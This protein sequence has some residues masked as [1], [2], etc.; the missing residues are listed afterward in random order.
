VEAIE[1]SIGDLPGF[2]KA[3]RLTAKQFLEQHPGKR[4]SVVHAGNFSPLSDT[5]HLEM[6][7]VRRML[8]EL[9]DMTTDDGS[10][11]LGVSSM[12]PQFVSGT[13]QYRLRPHLEKNFEKVEYFSPKKLGEEFSIGGQMGV[14]ICSGLKR[15]AAASQ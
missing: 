6:G 11:L 3:H 13:S 7:A 12:D 1:P 2:S 10:L 4:F 15:Q 9:R 14:F 5:G 8:A